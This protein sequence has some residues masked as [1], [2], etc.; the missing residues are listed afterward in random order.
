MGQV[1]AWLESPVTTLLAESNSHWKTL[2]GQLLAGRAVG[3]MV[4]DGNDGRIA[5]VRHSHGVA[6][7]W[8]ADR[9]FS[10]FPSLSVRNP[11]L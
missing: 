2:K 11:I 6:E 5:A 3:P 10:R 1:D 8:T 9:D 7:F 4:H